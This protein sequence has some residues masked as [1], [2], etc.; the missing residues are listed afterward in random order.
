MEGSGGGGGEEEGVEVRGEVRRKVAR[1][2][3]GVGR[4]KSTERLDGLGL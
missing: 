3:R 4:R 1:E 2:G